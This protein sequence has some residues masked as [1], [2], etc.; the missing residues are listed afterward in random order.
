MS[1]QF[2]H[3]SHDESP[4]SQDNEI[5][6]FIDHLPQEEQKPITPQETPDSESEADTPDQEVSSP[7]ELDTT[8]QTED[9]AAG[10]SNL[11]Q[12]RTKHFFLFGVILALTSAAFF[13]GGYFLPMGPIWQKLPRPQPISITQQPD[14]GLIFA[15][16]F[17][18]EFDVREKVT[19]HAYRDQNNDNR[20]D[21]REPALQGVNLNLSLPETPNVVIASGTTDMNGNAVIYGVKPG[22]YAVR[23][24][25]NPPYYPTGVYR[26]YAAELF[27]VSAEEFPQPNNANRIFPS[28]SLETTVQP[29]KT[30]NIAIQ[31]YEPKNIVIG[32]RNDTVVFYDTDIQRQIAWVGSQETD[33]GSQNFWFIG[34]DAYFLDAAGDVQKYSYKDNSINQVLKNPGI[35]RVAGFEYAMLSPGG[36]SL[37]F[38]IIAGSTYPLRLASDQTSCP[39]SEI[40]FQGKSLSL[41]TNSNPD[42]FFQLSW[43]DDTRFWFAAKDTSGTDRLFYARCNEKSVDL[44]QATIRSESNDHFYDVLA[45]DESHVLVS[46]GFV[47]PDPNS[48]SGGILRNVRGTGV[49]KLESDGSDTLHFLG[50]FRNEWMINPDHTWVATLDSSTQPNQL[51]FYRV[52]D[53]KEGKVTE[54]TTSGSYWKGGATWVGDVFYSI[55]AHQ[56]DGMICN[57]IQGYRPT[58]GGVQKLDALETKNEN[59]N[60]LLGVIKN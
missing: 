17:S 28:E 26:S 27:Q 45:L 37:A 30:W 34:Q 41:T 21:E 15:Q 55:S 35:M 58:D 52:N 42:H 14:P 59:L 12:K 22:K 38:A 31:K 20:L 23:F 2:D 39:N 36:K 44:R 40:Q 56:C 46:G 50:S 29:D 8:D 48:T 49:V 25:Y 57:T 47:E 32:S 9:T 5:R 51:V 13:I 7:D 60:R 10:S 1:T 16:Q 3:P 11:P 6:L 4:F 53:L 33:Y 43:L 18:S 19:I 54:V 24:Y